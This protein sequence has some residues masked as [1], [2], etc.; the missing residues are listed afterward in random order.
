MKKIIEKE[1]SDPLKLLFIGNSA[2]F[3]HE[4]PQKLQK[5]CEKAGYKIETYQLTPPSFYLI[6]HADET[7]DH[8]KA[9]LQEIKNGYDIVFLQENST[10]IVTEEKRETC[11]IG[12]QKLIE[13]IKESGAKPVF[14]VRPPTGKDLYGIPSLVQCEEYDK[15]FNEIANKHNMMC[16]YVNRAFAYAIKNF[17]YNLWGDD[18]AHVSEYGAYLIACTFF[19]ALFSTSSSVLDFDGLPEETAR[20]LQLAADKI[21]LEKYIPF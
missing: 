21:S 15:L 11:K 8:G 1:N 6:Q 16:V 19:G 5:L 2:T 13:K 12:S 18:N 9:V 4:I 17:D 7:T 20:N 10:C 14:Y 3:V